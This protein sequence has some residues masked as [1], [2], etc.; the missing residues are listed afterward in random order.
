M[1]EAR[2]NM[3][4]IN[5]NRDKVRKYDQALPPS[6]MNRLKN[7]ETEPNLNK[8]QYGMNS[9]FRDIKKARKKGRRKVMFYEFQIHRLF[10][11]NLSLIKTACIFSKHFKN[12]NTIVHI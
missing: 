4:V 12:E 5:R 11:N 6:A 7:I 8:I 9:T 10:L 3:P 1:F 2:V